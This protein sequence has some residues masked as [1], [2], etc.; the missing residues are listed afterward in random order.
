[1]IT[2]ADPDHSDG[3]ERSI[4]I[5]LSEILNVLW[6][7]FCERHEDTIRIISA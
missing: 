6:V 2:F 5:G 4:S 3:K 7:V 1:M